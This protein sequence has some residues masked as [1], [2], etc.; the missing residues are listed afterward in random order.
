[1]ARV[2]KISEPKADLSNLKLVFGYM[3]PHWKK[4]V[5]VFIA[6]L[7]S[8]SSV[9]SMGWGLKTMIDEGFSRKDPVMLRVALLYLIG[10]TVV[11]ALATFFRYVLTTKVGESVVAD[12]RRNV[13]RQLVHLSPAYFEDTRTGE[14][15]SRLS[16]D[17]TVLQLVIGTSLSIAVRNSLLL[18]GGVVMVL[19]TSPKLTIYIAVI[20]PV[21]V[22]VI[23]AMAGKVRRLSRK[24]QDKVADMS[25]HLDEVMRG[26]MT[27]QAYSRE[28]LEFTNFSRLAEIAKETAIARVK[29]RALLAAMVIFLV[30][31]AITLVMFLGGQEVLGGRISGGELSSFVFYSVL[32]ASSLGALSDVMGDLQRAAGAAERL[33]ELM[34]ATT[35]IV[36][37]ASPVPIPQAK[38]KVVFKNVSF[39]YPSKPDTKALED[40]SFEADAGSLIALVGPSG[41]G[42]STILKLILRF[43]DPQGGSVLFDGEDVRRYRLEEFRGQIAYVSQ[44]TVIFSGNLWENIRFGRQ[45][46]SDDEVIA[47]AKAAHAWEFIERL[48]HKMDTFVGERGMRLSGGEAQRVAI[49]RAILRKPQLLLLDE[50]TNAL[51]AENEKLVQE[52]LAKLMKECTTIVIAHRLATVLKADRIIVL[53][54]GTIE[55]M[56]THKEL[57]KQGALYARLAELQFKDI[58]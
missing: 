16:T 9:L 53:D 18:I 14:L 37:P 2:P 31:G 35:P 4:I 56:G 11:L 22:I 3:K 47:A 20:T 26:I 44:D 57:V 36:S 39:H 34:R 23:L 52:A 12:I 33:F 24:A 58:G 5:G 28:A 32:V 51:D 19:L 1:M 45:D 50:A 42:K 30:F 29:A 55:A 8:S 43:Y 17:T 54:H 10:V 21:I 27:V 25:S 48:P 13:F 6:L 40:I 41:A 38:G 7:I 49:A 15:I 46:A